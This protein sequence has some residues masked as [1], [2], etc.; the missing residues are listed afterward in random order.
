MNLIKTF[1]L[2][3]SW[4]LW[5]DAFEIDK[6]HKKRTPPFKM[7]GYHL[8]FLNG[9]PHA[10]VVNVIQFLD[11]AIQTGRPFNDDPLL[12]EDEV[13]AHCYGYNKDTLAGCL[14]GKG[15]F[16]VRQFIALKKTIDGFRSMGLRLDVKGHYELDPKS[17]CPGMDMDIVRT[18]L[19]MDWSDSLAYMMES[20][21]RKYVLDAA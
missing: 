1:L 4:S 2:H 13:G 15:V 20:E 7:I 11:G 18:F 3:Y 5:G 9:K 17:S 14:I 12:D 19:A 10:S 21:M 8:I 16:S 6:W